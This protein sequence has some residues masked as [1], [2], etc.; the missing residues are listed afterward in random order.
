[1]FSCVLVLL[2][3]MKS[4][5]KEIEAATPAKIPQKFI[6]YSSEVS[7]FP[8]PKII[9]GLITNM[10]PASPNKLAKIS[11]LLSLSLSRNQPRNPIHIVHV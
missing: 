4:T 10:I 1:M 6:I 3:K 7:S 8:N 11:Y 9:S 5:V 2:I